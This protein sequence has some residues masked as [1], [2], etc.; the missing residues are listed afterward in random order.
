MVD[1]ILWHFMGRNVKGKIIHSLSYYFECDIT[2]ESF[3]ISLELNPSPLWNLVIIV[4]SDLA[5]SIFNN[6]LFI[7]PMLICLQ[8]EQ[9]FLIFTPGQFWL[10]G[11]VVASVCLCVRVHM[12]VQAR[13]CPRHNSWRLQGQIKLKFTPCWDCPCHNSSP[14]Q[15]R[16]TVFGPEVQNTLIK[17]LIFFRIGW[18]W[19]S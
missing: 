18:C 11:V 17:I 13:S 12:C 15:A 2:M 3:T 5:L 4:S 1:E 16:I 6:K 9:R 8:W 10:L 7:E 14:I 19:Y